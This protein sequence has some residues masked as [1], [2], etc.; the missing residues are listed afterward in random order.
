MGALLAS[1]ALAGLGVKPGDRVATIAPNTH[2]QL[3]AF[4]AVPQL[5]AVLVPIN[6]RLAADDYRRLEHLLGDAGVD[7]AP[8]ETGRDTLAAL[9]AT[10]EPL[11]DGLAKYL[12]LRTPGWLPDDDANDN[13]QQGPRGLIAGRL[14]DELAGRWTHAA[15]DQAGSAPVK[16]GPGRWRGLRQRLRSGSLSG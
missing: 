16:A 14:I 9:R 13:W 6:Y 15:D 3:E 4:Y 5:G 7:W 1:A 12:L 8:G 11:L 10:Y 2:A